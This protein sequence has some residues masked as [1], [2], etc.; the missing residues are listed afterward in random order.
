MV[1][2]RALV[3]EAL[4]GGGE[5]GE[6]ELVETSPDRVADSQAGSFRHGRLGVA[7][8]AD[9][10]AQGL[11]VAKKRVPVRVRVRAQFIGTSDD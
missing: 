3:D 5:S 6:L 8:S 2:H 7:R 4:E 1:S 10:V 9:D 11:S